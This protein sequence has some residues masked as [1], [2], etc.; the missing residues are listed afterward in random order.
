MPLTFDI[1]FEQLVNYNGINPKPNDFDLYWES[2]LH[3]MRLLL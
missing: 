1:P 2:G 3:E